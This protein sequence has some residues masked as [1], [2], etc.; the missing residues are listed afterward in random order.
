MTVSAIPLSVRRDGAQVAAALDSLHERLAELA[1]CKAPDPVDAESCPAPLLLELGRRL[2]LSDPERQC[3]LFAAAAELCGTT[4]GLVAR[5]GSGPP[6]V[7][8]AMRVCDG[9][10]WQALRPDGAL[11]RAR[12]LAIGGEGRFT[13]RPM[14][15]E[16][17]VLHFLSGVSQ[18]A[19]ALAALSLAI[20]PHE[21]PTDD[22]TVAE[23]AARIDVR[24]SAPPVALA[25]EDVGEAIGHAIEGLRR[26]GLGALVLPAARLPQI[27][28]EL[29]QLQNL[30]LRDSLLHG[31][32]LVLVCDGA[33]SPAQLMGWT[34]PVI[35]AGLDAPPPLLGAHRISVQHDRGKR[36]AA[37]GAAL[38]DAQAAH[39]GRLDELA[40]RFRLSTPAIAALAAAH[41][42]D[43]PAR[44][45]AAAR[46]AARPRDMALIDRIE[47][48]VT[49][50]RVILPDDARRTLETIVSAARVHHRILDQWSGTAAG[51]R[52]LGIAALFSGESGTG[53]TMAAEAVARALGLDLYRVEVSAIVSKYIGETEKNL[54]R[55]FA[56]A[57][58]GGG[59][60]LFD[61]AD[62]IFGKRS[63]VR[64]AVD[65]YANMEVGY[66]LQLMEGFAGLAILTT[67][68]RDALDEA[69]T[70]RLR[71]I[72]QFPMP[73]IDERR[74]IWERAFPPGL[75]AAALDCAR[76]A[77]LPLS[78]GIIRNIALGAAFR[79]A[80][81]GSGDALTMDH[82]L[83]AAREEYLKL[84]RPVA[85]IEARCWS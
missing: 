58:A 6:S 39:A 80:A 59:V 35:L 14:W 34:G 38:G 61:E 32:G 28:D 2:A 65:R 72:L 53:K 82:V 13:E 74:R 26:A 57:E 62:A 7:A 23:I 17:P 67:N 64:D 3:L 51:G 37:W 20:G 47:P 10:D 24:F 68:L 4:A 16:E 54:R 79:A 63:E 43:E 70:R 11:R 76:L 78:G 46:D 27:V 12:L 84:G 22:A 48:V 71:F 69:F 19:P 60:L 83:D 5:I 66:L 73:G 25:C 44:L 31:L 42:R 30:W 85:E 50:D 1:G 52:G 56:A 9:L 40:A 75:D 55:I 36:R 45:W 77:R 33:T 49:L 41:G 29:D 81:Q 8:L 15:V 18:L 21:A